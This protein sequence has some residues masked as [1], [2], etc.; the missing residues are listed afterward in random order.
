MPTAHFGG[1]DAHHVLSGGRRIGHGATL[2]CCPWHHRGVKPYEQMTN[3]Q[4][5]AHF[6]PSL[7]HGSKPFHA[8][9]GSDGD[10]LDL[11]EQLLAGGAPACE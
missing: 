10:L 1:C 5:T 2:A 9:Y 11:Q 6:G 7:A 8:V 3:D 4:A